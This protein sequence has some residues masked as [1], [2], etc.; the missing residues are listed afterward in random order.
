MQVWR[1][2]ADKN[3]SIDSGDHVYIYQPMR[4]GGTGIYALDVTNRNDPRLRWQIRGSGLDASPGGDYRD[5]A[6]TWSTPQRATIQWCSNGNCSDREVLFFGGGYDPVHDSATS[7]VSSSTGNA[8]YMVDASTGELIWSAGDGSHHDVNSNL[9]TNSFTADVFVGGTGHEGYAE[10]MFAVDIQGNLFRFDFNPDASSASNFISSY[11]QIASLGG[12][13]SNFRRFY[14]QPDVGFF[15]PRGEEPFLTISIASGYRAHPRNEGIDDRLYLL[16]DRNAIDPP[17]DYS[18]ASGGMVTESD[19]GL[20]GSPTTHGWYLPL[21]GDGE[22]GLARTV[23]FR[24]KILMATYLPGDTTTCEGS[25][26]DGRYYIL[27]A[28]TGESS[29]YINNDEPSI[30]PQNT[31]DT[32]HSFSQLG[33]GGIPPEPTLIFTPRDHCVSDCSSANPVTQ[34]RTEATAC[35]GTECFSADIEMPLFKSYWRAN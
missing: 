10:F 29:L 22:K 12:S 18:Y 25:I 9:L 15:A 35:I 11:G 20:A 16:I 2:D 17:S 5:L 23:T 27:D 21:Q 1:Y 13:G 4:R 6:Q 7:P 28:L 26:G 8:L 32:P 31:N 33:H 34:K 14:N 19:L 30:E 3:G 24:E